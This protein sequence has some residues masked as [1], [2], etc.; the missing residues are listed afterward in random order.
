VSSG[1]P[2]IGRQIDHWIEDNPYEIGINWIGALEA[3]ARAISWILT[4]PFYAECADQAFRQRLLSSVAQHLLFVEQHLSTG[5][6]A[7]THLVGEAAALVIGGLFLDCRHSARWVARGLSILDEEIQ[8]QVTRDGVHAERSPSYHRFF[9]DHYY[10]VAAVLAA[11]G[12]RMAASTLRRVELMTEFLMQVLT[13]DGSVPGFGDADEAR[14]L[15]VRSASPGDY[16]GLLALGGVLFGRQDFKAVAGDAAEEV[17]WLFGVE[18]MRTYRTLAVR[19]PERGAVA[20][21]DGG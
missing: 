3:G 20:Y 8:R 19:E 5:P 14:G 18:G 13:P 6:F 1:A 16:R 12:R 15:W 2:E 4:Y 10:L 17:L 9:L 7:N 21:A 11:N